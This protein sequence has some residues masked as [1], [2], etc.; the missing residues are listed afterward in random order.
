MARL[1]L[2]SRLELKSFF[3]SFICAPLKKVSFTTLLYVSPVQIHPV[4]IPDGNSSPL[5]F[6][7]NGGSRLFDEST[8]RRPG[9]HGRDE[10][11]PG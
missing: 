10:R 2:P 11:L 7:D 9:A 1:A 8:Q 5:P 4:L 3:G 6:F